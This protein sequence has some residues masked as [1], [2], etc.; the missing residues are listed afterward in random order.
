M[1]TRTHRR[2]KILHPR[3]TEPGDGADAFLPDYRSG[4]VPAKEGDVEAYGEEFVFAATSNEPVGEL[5]RS[6]PAAA[7]V[8]GIMVD[9]EDD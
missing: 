9:L 5:A 8:N 6:E 3:R 2:T 4:F 1:N 7:D